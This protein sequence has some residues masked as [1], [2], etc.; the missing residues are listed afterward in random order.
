MTQHQNPTAKAVG[1]LSAGGILVLSIGV[2]IGCQAINREGKPVDYYRVNWQWP[3]EGQVVK[4]LPQR[5]RDHKGIL[6]IAG[7]E[8]RPILAAEQGTVVYSGEAIAGYGKLVILK[9]SNDYLTAYG[10]NQKILVNEGERVAK[11]QPIA[12]MGLTEEGRAALLFEIRHLS[13][14]NMAEPLKDPLTLL[15]PR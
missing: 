9:H 10:A 7:K 2:L 14:H 4:D 3:T 8:G 6:L 5:L 13:R 11:G 1:K 12:R 15:P